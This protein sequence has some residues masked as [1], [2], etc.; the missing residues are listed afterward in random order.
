[1]A[2]VTLQVNNS[3]AA[4]TSIL[5]SNAPA[6]SADT[7]ITVTG[8]NFVSGAVVQF[9]ETIL[10]TTLVNST[11]LTALIPAGKLANAGTYNV[12]VYNTAPGG[13]S[14]GSVP[15]IVTA[16]PGSRRRGQITS[17]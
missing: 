2:P 4:L 9:G 6:G 10:N 14:S 8:T 11:E 13:G 16:I 7:I 1:V 15:F 12:A 17:Q 5:P 3:P